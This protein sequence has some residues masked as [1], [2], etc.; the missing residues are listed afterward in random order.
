MKKLGEPTKMGEDHCPYC[1]YKIDMASSTRDDEKPQP[2][3]I[4]ICLNCTG[5]MSYGPDM[6]LQE[7][8]KVL[9]DTLDEGHQKEILHVQHVMRMV[10][11]EKDENT[12]SV[13]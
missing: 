9:F 12:R 2:G 6:A 8:P 13:L 3:D 4:S 1:D 7:F 5:V 11:K 10:K